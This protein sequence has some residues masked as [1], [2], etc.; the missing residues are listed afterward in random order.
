MGKFLNWFENEHEI[1]LVLKAAMPHLWF[2]SIHPFDDGN[3]RITRAITDMTLARSDKSVRRFYSMSAQIRV[4]RK[5]YYKTLEKTQKGSSDITA[6]L[7]WFLQCLINA[8]IGRASCR[9]RV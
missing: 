8:K 3:G 7:I 1:D 4:E 9:E 5:Q 6:W 2:V